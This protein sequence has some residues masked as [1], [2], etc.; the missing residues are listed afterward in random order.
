MKVKVAR[1]YLLELICCIVIAIGSIFMVIKASG[2]PTE[3]KIFPIAVLIVGIVASMVQ[4]IKL[5]MLSYRK[6][7]LNSQDEN[8]V[9]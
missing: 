1:A 7:S 2:Y 8:K 3:A 6:A 4:I 5:L 9:K